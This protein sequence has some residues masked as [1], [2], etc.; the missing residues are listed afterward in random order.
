[1]KKQRKVKKKP[2]KKGGWRGTRELY[3]GPKIGNKNYPFKIE[4]INFFNCKEGKDMAIY[5]YIDRITGGI[6]KW[7]SQL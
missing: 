3:Q 2:T 1:M 5:L 6:I 7:R 4:I